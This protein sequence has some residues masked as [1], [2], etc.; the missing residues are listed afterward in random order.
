MTARDE[1]WWPSNTLPPDPDATGELG[2]PHGG[3]PPPTQG[4]VLGDTAERLSTCAVEVAVAKERIHADL[5][6][7]A[8]RITPRSRDWYLR[9]HAVILAAAAVA[10]GYAAG[11]WA[12]EA[13]VLAYTLGAT[14]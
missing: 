4:D 9:R 12:I 8:D 10:F 13:A 2:P 5:T 11:R 7:V 6:A 1:L 3:F 14:P